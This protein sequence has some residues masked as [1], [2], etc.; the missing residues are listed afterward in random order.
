[1]VS[2]VARDTSRALLS[3]PQSTQGKLTKKTQANAKQSDEEQTN[4]QQGSTWPRQS[5]KTISNICNN[6]KIN[7]QQ[8]KQPKQENIIRRRRRTTATTTVQKTYIKPTLQNISKYSVVEQR[9]WEETGFSLNWCM[10]NYLQNRRRLFFKNLD[11]VAWG[12]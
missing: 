7:K 1:M 12:Q 3:L 11:P 4:D 2:D 6:N 10:E 8:E 9:R 5:P